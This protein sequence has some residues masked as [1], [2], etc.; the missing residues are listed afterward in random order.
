MSIQTYAAGN[1]RPYTLDKR[2]AFPISGDAT[3]RHRAETV[4]GL[5]PSVNVWRG[6]NVIPSRKTYGIVPGSRIRTWRGIIEVEAVGSIA[7][8]GRL[9]GEEVR[10]EHFQVLE[11]LQPEVADRIKV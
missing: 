10:W 11:V 4:D 9:N 8:W 3:A 7:G 2:R 1:A 6:R 5:I